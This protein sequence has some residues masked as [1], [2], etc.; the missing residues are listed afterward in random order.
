MFL[1]T[2]KVEK[3]SYTKKDEIGSILEKMN[4]VHDEI[5]NLNN[6]DMKILGEMTLILSKMEQGIFYCQVKSDTNNFM[7]KSLKNF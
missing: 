3:A 2:Y 4:T 6:D 5:I 1:K 7:L